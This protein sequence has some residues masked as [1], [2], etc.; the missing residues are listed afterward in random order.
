MVRHFTPQLV[1]AILVACI[2]TVFAVEACASTP[3]ESRVIADLPDVTPTNAKAPDLYEYMGDRYK[4][5]SALLRAISI[6]ES[7]GYP[8]TVDLN[9]YPFFFPTKAKAN[10]FINLS[11]VRSWLVVVTYKTKPAERY[12]YDSEASANALRPTL[13][14]VN[15]FTV[16]HVDSSNIDLGLMQ[17]NWGYHGTEAPS[18]QRLMDTDYNVAF[19]A[20]LL[21]KLIKQYKNV[22]T[23]VGYYHSSDPDERKRYEAEVKSVY[24]KMLNE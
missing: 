8:W 5:E 24:E 1:C 21:S 18:M 11:K 20:H 3:T 15:S 6:V 7:H 9:G 23:A 12:L 17:I 10:E 16:K 4:V 2:S 13:T 14:D 19:G 22:W